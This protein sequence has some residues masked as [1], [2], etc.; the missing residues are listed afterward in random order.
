V[1]LIRSLL[2]PS[3]PAL[4]A[5]RHHARSQ[6]ITVTVGK[7]W[8]RCGQESGYTYP[9][10]SGVDRLLSY[11]LGTLTNKIRNKGMDA[12]N[13]V[14]TVVVAAV[15]VLVVGA[16]GTAGADPTPEPS[17]GY[18]IQGPTG[19]TVGGLRSLPPI[20]GVQPRACAGNWDP[21]TGAWV[22]PP[23]T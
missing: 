13:R 16:T 6:G 12:M 14:R 3:K 15:A 21:N 9:I 22:F 10:R 18:V 7:M 19:P 4:P 1:V 20:C 17:P 5:Q 23:G 11:L 8:A 2:R